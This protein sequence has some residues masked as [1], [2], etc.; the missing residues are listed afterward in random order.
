MTSF[1]LHHLLKGPTSST[2]TWASTYELCERDKIQST[3]KVEST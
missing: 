1:D 2:V 3:E